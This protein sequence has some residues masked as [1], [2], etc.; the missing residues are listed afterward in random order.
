MNRYRI[1]GVAVAAAGVLVVPAQSASAVTKCAVGTWRVNEVQ[2]EERLIDGTLDDWNYFLKGYGKIR[3]K[4]TATRWTY[5]LNASALGRYS[6]TRNGKN[7]EGIRRYRGKVTMKSMIS[8]TRKGKIAIKLR[9]ATG[10]A[11]GWR[12]DTAPKLD[13]VITK[14]NLI[15]ALHLPQPQGMDAFPELVSYTCTATTMKF[16]SKY[17]FEGS[18]NVVL[19]MHLTRIS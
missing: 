1:A 11:T 9:S 3:L 2:H 13:P 6:G 5:D 10:K 12:R 8:G 15:S 16:R 17:Q 18:Q 14:F 7:F 19:N 4:L